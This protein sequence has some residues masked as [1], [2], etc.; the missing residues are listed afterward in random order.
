MGT[1]TMMRTILIGAAVCAIASLLPVNG[2]SCSLCGPDISCPKECFDEMVQSGNCPSNW[3]HIKKLNNCKTLNSPQKMRSKV[4]SLLGAACTGAVQGKCS[5]SGGTPTSN[6]MVYG[7]EN[8]GAHS[9]CDTVSTTNDDGQ[10]YTWVHKKGFTS[11][12]TSTTSKTS[13]KSK[14]KKKGE[15]EDEL[16]RLLDA[17]DSSG[18]N[19]KQSWQC[20]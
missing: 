4:A 16:L 5:F 8:G 6:C 12:T 15:E 17:E 20:W 3:G 1:T 7:M 19:T 2:Q 9:H 13:K 18:A 14:A 10:T 11:M